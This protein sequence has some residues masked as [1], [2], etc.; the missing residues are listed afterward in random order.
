M[1]YVTVYTTLPNKRSAQ[2]LAN[3]IIKERLAACANIFP[4][5]SVYTWEKKVQKGSEIAI[6]FKTKKSKIVKI[7]KTIKSNHPYKV[8]CITTW[9][10]DGDKDYLKWIDRSC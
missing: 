5:S 10:I 9:S 3:L 2:R 4:I 6:F 8:P 1:N 7:K